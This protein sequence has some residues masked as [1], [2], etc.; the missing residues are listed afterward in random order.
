MKELEKKSF[1]VEVNRLRRILEEKDKQLS[2][3][4]FQTNDLRH[5]LATE[6]LIQHFPR[7]QEISSGWTPEGGYKIM[8]AM[9][10]MFEV[11]K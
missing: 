6:P 2:E 9:Q 4:H 7:L 11:K 3:L 5:L 8:I 1:E 10:I